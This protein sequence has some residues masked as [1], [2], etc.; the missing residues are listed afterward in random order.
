MIASGRLSKTP[1]STQARQVEKEVK[2]DQAW[3]D[4]IKQLQRFIEKTYFIQ[5]YFDSLTIAT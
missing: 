1:V 2:L 5:I 4:S 3:K